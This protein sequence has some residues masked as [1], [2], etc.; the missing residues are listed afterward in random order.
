MVPPATPEA[1]N[2]RLLEYSWAQGLMLALY[3]LLLAYANDANCPSMQLDEV[4]ETLDSLRRV[5]K[6]DMVPGSWYY[7]SNCRTLHN[8]GTPGPTAVSGWKTVRGR[9][10]ICAQQEPY[11]NGGL[12]QPHLFQQGQEAPLCC[13]GRKILQGSQMYMT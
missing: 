7:L 8:I 10:T 12:R 11:S 13:A 2:L 3:S 5:H 9:R 4:A 1:L 6:L